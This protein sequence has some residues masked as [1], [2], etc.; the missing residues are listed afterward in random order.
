M[1]HQVVEEVVVAVEPSPER[2]PSPPDPLRSLAAELHGKFARYRESYKNFSTGMDEF[3]EE[4]EGE[5]REEEEKESMEVV[6]KI[7]EEDAWSHVVSGVMRE[8]KLSTQ[9]SV[10][11]PRKDELEVWEAEEAAN[12][13]AIEKMARDMEL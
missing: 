5:L 13:A 10:E 9:S 4:I 12:Q 3:H 2:S 11:E 7:S 8:K 6:R 1:G